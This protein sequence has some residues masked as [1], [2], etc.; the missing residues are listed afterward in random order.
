M[1]RIILIL[2]AALAF[3][4]CASAQRAVVPYVGLSAVSNFTDKT[5]AGLSFGFRNY[6]R[7]SFLTLGFSTE[8][9]GY[10]YPTVKNFAAYAIPELGLGIGP[11]SFKIYPHSGVMLGYE[12]ISSAFSWGVKGGLSLDVGRVVSIDASFYLPDLNFSVINVGFGIIFRFG[13]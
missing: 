2:F 4:F 6:N 5:G 13:A 11:S 1:K 8:A 12:S 7:A 10:Y 9:F 3:S